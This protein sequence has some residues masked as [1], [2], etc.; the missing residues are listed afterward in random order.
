M[1]QPNPEQKPPAYKPGRTI[2]RELLA[3]MGVELA[4]LAR[5]KGKLQLSLKCLHFVADVQGLFDDDN[6]GF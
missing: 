4:D 1:H 2:N 5:E 6:D 3:N